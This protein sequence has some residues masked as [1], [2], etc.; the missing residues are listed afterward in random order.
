MV[1]TARM[2]RLNVKEKKKNYLS[3]NYFPIQ[4]LKI[5]N[6]K[7]KE[8]KKVWQ[9]TW[10]F[11]IYTHV[12]RTKEDKIILT[13]NTRRIIVRFAMSGGWKT[14]RIVKSERTHSLKAPD[15]DRSIFVGI[16][17]RAPRPDS[18]FNPKRIPARRRRP[19]RVSAARKIRNRLKAPIKA[20]D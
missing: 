7:K 9:N 4:S 5:R 17:L 16:S 8:R 15:L 3:E 6:K 12:S 11:H 18:R 13:S 14:A 19:R 1:F 2:A 10:L 20:R